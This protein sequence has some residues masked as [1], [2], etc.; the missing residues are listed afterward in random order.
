MTT[1][2]W[3][4]T[5]EMIDPRLI[6]IDH[7]FQR[8]EKES[9]ID[10]IAAN[11]LPMAFGVPVCFK[12]DNG[13]FYCAD[14]QQR[15][16]G[17]LKSANPP[18]LIP[19][20]WWT[21]AGVQHEAEIF[22]RINEYRKQLSP[23][24][25]HVAKLVAKD[26]ASVAIE[27]L[28]ETAG[29]SISNR[30]GSTRTIGAIAGLHYVYNVAGEEGA[31]QTLCVLRDAFPDD[32]RAFDTVLIRVIGDIVANANGSL[33]RA[34]LTQ[35]LAKTTT[36]KLTRRAEELHFKLGTSKRESLRTAV[37]EIVKL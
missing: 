27:R 13:V 35:A 19:T 14:G 23:H 32:R 18:L 11:P 28:V 25:K 17:V 37:S 15:I 30:S 5:I 8:P 22:V 12:R 1:K 20:V 26:P 2:W 29:L 6:V 24:E 33:S 3:D 34:K 4:G 21:V 16:K 7:R 10:A 36:G 31:L 9:L